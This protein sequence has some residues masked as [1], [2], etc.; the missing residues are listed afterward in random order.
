MVGDNTLSLVSQYKDEIFRELFIYSLKPTLKILTVYVLISFILYVYTNKT[1][2]TILYIALLFHTLP[3]LLYIVY[4]FE[5]NK[6]R[7][8]IIKYGKKYLLQGTKINIIGGNT[9]RKYFLY[10]IT[11]Y[12]SKYKIPVKEPFQA[13][14]QIFDFEPQDIY[15]YADIEKNPHRVNL[16]LERFTLRDS[17]GVE[18]SSTKAPQN[19]IKI[20]IAFI[21]L[22]IVIPFVLIFTSF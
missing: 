6:F 7:R 9:D 18:R 11:G 19:N 10:E 12:Y 20:F 5:K 16:L 8:H 22:M 4:H 17:K 15:L 14:R 21:V 13:K 3:I 1:G 2:N